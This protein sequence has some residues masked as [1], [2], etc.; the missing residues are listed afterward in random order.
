MASAGR[1][2]AKRNGAGGVGTVRKRTKE[3]SGF[4]ALD[5]QNMKILASKLVLIA[6]AVV[7]TLAVVGCDWSK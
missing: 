6:M 2:K 4:T 5:L 7:L 1:Y 3:S